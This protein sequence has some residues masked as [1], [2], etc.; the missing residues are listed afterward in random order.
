MTG[1]DNKGRFVKGNK[2]HLGHPHNKEMRENISKARKGKLIGLE[3]HFFGK[4]HTLASRRKMSLANLGRKNP[5]HSAYMRTRVGPLSS[6]WEGGKTSKAKLIRGSVM[7]REWR[8]T[9]FKKDNWTCVWC[10]TKSGNG[11]KVLL[12]ADHIKPF[13]LYPESRF[14]INNG[15]TLCIPCH[16]AT[17]TFGI[18][19]IKMKKSLCL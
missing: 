5:T 4:K 8:E 12:N 13:A 15:R 18:G 19:T 6:K 11:H 2:A 16:R 17:E 10:G 3:N 1:R 7:Y 14:D 9:V